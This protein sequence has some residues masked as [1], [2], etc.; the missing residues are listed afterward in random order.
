MLP[1]LL[2]L[3]AAPQA[4]QQAPPRPVFN[5]R[6]HQLVVTPPVR[7]ASAT[8]DGVLS[9]PVWREAALLTGFSQYMPRDDTPAADSTELLV[10][11]SRTAIHFGVRAFQP[12]ALVRATLADRDKIDQDDFVQLL[13]DTFNDGRQAAVF[14]V[15]PFGVQADG[16]LRESGNLPGGGFSSG[17]TQAREVPDLNP[18]FVFESKGRLTD[19]GYEVEIRIP[20]KSMRFQAVGVQTWGI[21]VIRKVQ[22]RGYEDSWAPA[23]RAAASFLGQSGK[24]AGLTDLRRGVVVDVTPEATQRTAGQPEP[25]GAGSAAPAWGYVA[26]RPQLGGNV[27]WGIT[28]NLNFSGTLSPDFSQVEADAATISS[29]PRNAVSVPE[30]RPF[31]LDGIEQFTTPNTLIYTR[32][33]VQP[34][35]AVK[36]VGKLGSSD[37]ALLSAVDAASASASKGDRPLV[38]VL[39]LQRDLGGQ[40]RIG[41]VYTD[42]VNGANSNRVLGVDSRIVWRKIHSLQLQLAGSATERAGMR[43]VGPLWDARLNMDGRSFGWRTQFTGI[44]DRFLTE[45]GFISRV[46]QAKL[47]FSPRYTWFG[48][49]GAFLETLSGD[50]RYNTNYDFRNFTR[51]GDAR[52]KMLHFDLFG[53]A[54]GGWTA[55]LSLLIESFGYDPGYYGKLYRIEVPRPNGLPSDTLP[56]TG[57][58][59]LPNRDWALTIGTPQLKWISFNALYLIGQ[60]ENYSEWSSGN[61][62]H[63][64]VTANIRPSEKL[65]IAANY[66]ERDYRRVTNGRQVLLKRDPRLKIEYQVT[67]SIFVRAIGEYFS[68]Y[69]DSLFDDSRTGLPLLSYDAA[70][71]RWT[72]TTAHTENQ[73]HGELLFSYRP[74]PGTVFYAGYGADLSEPDA[75]RFGAMRRKSDAFFLKASYLFRL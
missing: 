71:K 11:Y 12:R 73:P 40:S 16:I 54:R 9:E 56:F 29:D 10:W 50:I 53:R 38:N 20:F 41:M 33:I 14:S 2:L 25:T 43:T 70:R 48:R 8:V 1:L 74:A 31:F 68:T 46:G 51:R 23:Q 22:Y 63:L 32:R 18:D 3:L 57:T 5:G 72:R 13:L 49:R 26:Q 15:N 37:I 67:R 17:T 69:T 4:A 62:M 24:L 47:N 19:F 55:G 59:R 60:D 34:V 28:N 35:A 52:D 39:R 42:R 75:Y 21:N 45:S 36:L 58:P 27:R 66:E 44:S 30:K 7:D 65:R 6:A 61:L 64:V